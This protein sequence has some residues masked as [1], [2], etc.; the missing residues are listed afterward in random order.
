MRSTCPSV[1]ACYLHLAS[2]APGCLPR[3]TLHAFSLT[4]LAA[5]VLTLCISL[6]LT[7][8]HLLHSAHCLA[9]FSFTAHCPCLLP[10]CSLPAGETPRTFILETPPPGPSKSSL[11]SQTKSRRAIWMR[12][13]MA[14]PTKPQWQEDFGAEC[15]RVLR[16]KSNPQFQKP[17]IWMHRRVGLE[18]SPSR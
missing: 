15:S 18:G 13:T 7:H 16:S 5:L 8:S 6:T 17:A 14:N 3:C 10:H 1:S 12:K 4:Q 11:Q 2:R 9:P